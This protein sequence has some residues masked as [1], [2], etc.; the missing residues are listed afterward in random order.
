[1]FDTKVNIDFQIYD[2][3]KFQQLEKR[4]SDAAEIEIDFNRK[5]RKLLTCIKIPVTSNKYDAYLSFI[6]GN[7]L[8][9]I[10]AEYGQIVL[11][12]NVRSFLQANNKTNRAI[13]N[14]G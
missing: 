5:P 10:Y 12:S 6:P 8:A 2:I 11:E 14:T 4:G 1:M 7:T 13:K 9:D 3:K